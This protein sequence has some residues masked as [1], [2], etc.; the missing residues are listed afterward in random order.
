MPTIPPKIPQRIPS[1]VPGGPVPSR[2]RHPVQSGRIAATTLQIQLPT[3]EQPYSFANSLARFGSRLGPIIA[4]PVINLARGFWYFISG[5]T[6]QPVANQISPN[7][8]VITVHERTRFIDLLPEGVAPGGINVPV[9]QGPIGNC[10]F[11]SSFLVGL[12]QLFWTKQLFNWIIL[13]ADKP[14][15]PWTV[16]N[17]LNQ[18]TVI[19]AYDIASTKNM[20]VSGQ[21]LDKI[22]EE[23]FYR[24][25]PGS[26][27]QESGGSLQDALRPFFNFKQHVNFNSSG[28][29]QIRIPFQYRSDTAILSKVKSLL[30]QLHDNPEST[31]IYASAYFG[32]AEPNQPEDL[33]T[34]FIEPLRGTSSGHAYS[35]ESYEPANNMLTIINPHDSALLVHRVSLEN[36]LRIF[37]YIEVATFN[38]NEITKFMGPLRESDET[39]PGISGPLRFGRHFYSYSPEQVRANLQIQLSWDSYYHINVQPI[40][41]GRAWRIKWNALDATHERLVYRGRGGVVLGRRTFANDNPAIEQHHMEV[42][43]DRSGNLLIRSLATETSGVARII[44]GV[45]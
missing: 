13:N 20:Q 17:F 6:P 4:T 19:N 36:F 39:K 38:L 16:R 2:M 33:R 41:G 8:P 7:D 27:L 24:F 42:M 34:L 40:D 29:A 15:G 26:R 30:M 18:R 22:L 12:K 9:R 43:V 32:E 21:L 11:V 44:A 23:A 3:A 35:I 25:S 28:G 10:F 5:R 45:F 37:G 14:S 31:L 1:R